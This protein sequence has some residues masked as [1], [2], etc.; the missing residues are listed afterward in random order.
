M[1]RSGNSQV[2]NIVIGESQSVE[3]YDSNNQIDKYYSQIENNKQRALMQK[4]TLPG[5]AE[6][7]MGGSSNA[8]DTSS[9]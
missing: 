1:T 7:Q 9:F 6:Y 2:T 4:N 8:V 5:I 3:N